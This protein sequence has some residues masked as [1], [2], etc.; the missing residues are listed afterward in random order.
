MGR[1]TRSSVPWVSLD[2]QPGRI[3]SGKYRVEEKIG[4]G[5]EGEVYRITEVATRIERVAKFYF[6]ERNPKGR[7]AARY[8]RRLHLLKHCHIVTQYHHQDRV[9]LRRQGVD[10]QVDYVVS[11]Y[12]EG[13]VLSRFLA[14]QRGKRLPPFEALHLLYGLA[15]G[16]VPVQQAGQYHGDIHSDNILVRRRGVGFE[17]KLLDFFDLGAPTSAKMQRDIVDMSL[18]LHEMVGGVRHYARQPAIVKHFCAGRRHGLILRRFPTVLAMV[19]DMESWTWEE[20][21]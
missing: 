4:E 21:D 18:L 2:F 19:K 20:G 10:Y 1:S 16:I 14:R 12:A 5:W 6:P 7:I 15:L 8:A 9:R 13:E 17:L 3:L 11:D